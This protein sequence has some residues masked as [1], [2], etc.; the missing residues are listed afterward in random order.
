MDPI[1][2][3]QA[4]PR[5]AGLRLFAACGGRIPR[6]IPAALLGAVLLALG[7]LALAPGLSLPAQA[8][9]GPDYAPPPGLA[10]Q[11]AH[12]VTA[13]REALPA[14]QEVRDEALAGARDQA[15]E[16][17]NWPRAIAF[18]QQIVQRSLAAGAAEAASALVAL[19]GLHLEA[20]N[21]QAAAAAAFAAVE[22]AR[23][24]ADRSAGLEAL[25]NAL[26]DR[27]R[28]QE[29]AAALRAAQAA[30]PDPE[31]LQDRLSWLESMYLLQVAN[32]QVFADQSIPE[33]CIQFNRPLAQPLPLPAGDYLS[34][35]PGVRV[36]V[37][38]GADRLCIAGLEHGGSYQAVVRR[39]LP[40]AD[41]AALAADARL[42]IDI[43][44]RPA[45]LGFPTGPYVLP[46]A[47]VPAVDLQSV[48]VGLVAL[49]LV[50]ITENNLVNQLRDGLFNPLY[51]GQIDMI[52]EDI[53][54]EVWRGSMEV[55]GRLN[56]EQRTAVPLAEMLRTPEPGIYVL[57]ATNGDD[58]EQADLPWS[59]WASQWIV[60]SDIGL[61]SYQG[62]DGM[63]VVARSLQ[64]A[65]PKAG[66][67]LRLVSR[68]NQVLDRAVT[69]AQGLARFA[70][71]LLRGTGGNRPAVLYAEGARGG[72][73][74][75]LEL[76]GAALEL[77]ERGVA[78]RPAPGPVD[79]YLYADRGIF[80]PGETLDVN[81]LARDADG[82]A[83]PGMPVV[84]SLKRPD[85][86]EAARRTAVTDELGGLRTGFVI[87]D[88][89]Q[90]GQ[91]QVDA[92]ADPAAA[93][94]G[95]LQVVVE[96]FVPQRIALELHSAAAAI[97][98]GTPVTVEAR[99]EYLYGAPAADLPVKGVLTL[100]RDPEPY[101]S[102]PGYHFGL[103]EDPYSPE[104][105]PLADSRTDGEGIGRLTVL[106]DDLP[107]A[108]Q[109]LRARIAVSLFDEGGRPVNRSLTLPVHT[110]TPAIGLK[111]DFPGNQL[112]EGQAAAFDL[113]V[114]D[115]EGAPVA[116]AELDIAW[117]E[118]Q[119]DY[120]WY[121]EDG[122]LRYRQTLRDRAV[123]LSRIATDAEGRARIEQRLGWG[124]YR[125]A[126]ADRAAGAASSFRF[127][128]GW[129]VSPG[130]PDTPDALDLVLDA[131]PGGDAREV[132]A[133]VKAP[134]AGV[135]E[136]MVVNEALRYRR[137][138]PLPESGAHVSIPVQADWGVGAYV[139]A[140]AYRP[141]GGE[142]EGEVP[143][144][145]SRAMGAA[146]FPIGTAARTLS[147]ALDPPAR[148]RPGNRV[149]LPL[150]VTAT[151]PAAL[152]GGLKLAVAAVDEGV[153]QLTG[154]QSP[155]P[156]DHFFGQRR[157]AM[158]I[159]DLYGRLIAPATGQ[160]GDP[161]G[162]GDAAGN[163]GGLAVQTTRV[164]A[165]Y[166]GPVTPD[167][168]GRAVVEFDLPEGFNGRLRLMAVA[169]GRTAVGAGSAALTVRDPVV[170]SMI[171]P[172]FLAPGDEAEAMLSLDNVDGGAGSYV[173]ELAAD[174]AVD[175]IDGARLEQALDAGGRVRHRVTLSGTEVGT[176]RLALRLTGPGGLEI[177]Q[178]WEIA[179]RPA[180]P[181]QSLRS[182]DLLA[183][184]GALTSRTA[185]A[186]GMIADTATV[187]L[188]VSATPDID[189]PGLLASL[190]DY[191]YRCLEQMVSVAYPQLQ[192]R[193]MSA[194][195]QG[196]EM[197]PVA[198]EAAVQ[199]A[200]RGSI[201]RQR[202]DGSFGLW[203]MSGPADPWL[204]IYA[205][206]FLSRARG[207]G[208][209]LPEPVLVQG[210]NW[211]LSALQ[212]APDGLTA[213]GQAYAL[214]VLAR[215]AALDA[216]TLRYWADGLAE[217]VTSPLGL[218]FLGSAR[219]AAGEPL[220]QVPQLVLAAAES[221]AEPRPED[222]RDYGSSLRDAAA[223]LAV[224]AESGAP[225][226]SLLPLLTAVAD[227][228]AT[229]QRLSTQEEAW[230]L[231]A[232]QAMA[233]AG[234]PARPLLLEVAGT[235]TGPLAEPYAR[236]LP[237][238]APPLTVRNLGEEPVWAYQTVRGV[239]AASL[240]PV[241]EGLTVTRR[242]FHL[243][244]SEANPADVRQNDQMVV[245]LEGGA[246]PG[247]R[248][249]ALV[250]DLLPAGFEIE[251]A[252]AGGAVAL[253]ALPFL[254]MLSEPLFVGVRAD[255]Y[256][257]AIDLEGDTD[258]FAF[259]YL[260]RAVTPGRFVHPAPFVE[261]M[262]RPALFARGAMGEVH[263]SRP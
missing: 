59:D 200:I 86:R 92:F 243:D 61:A 101:P 244:G 134:F 168:Q 135:L 69:D 261:D 190:R 77:G 20:G 182:V 16:A 70:P 163:L 44:Q 119:A 112:A 234:G 45:S 155:D 109:P 239:P 146:W 122:R 248:H 68:N 212:N 85:G 120:F 51:G 143:R 227:S 258:R 115:A 147:V 169:W 23:E 95:S 48:N 201:A 206:D 84:L 114:V 224:L 21:A 167:A 189:V 99:G 148:A 157:L 138:V 71:G 251:S 208:Q 118:E 236:Q 228:A 136:I 52:A 177:A 213:D 15:Q 12:L 72:D 217:R 159:H 125:L 116:G 209:D 103:V 32:V 247:G 94:V 130:L 187:S 252:A 35:T 225:G 132:S 30:A 188:N 67:E 33:A 110:P 8:G 175:V 254:P 4:I 246:A 126:V 42:A 205:M 65:A 38:A 207:E 235:A 79:A 141:L 220:A 181:W 124:R 26:A 88:A 47:R 41:G 197:D 152:A 76:T 96:D 166:Q 173:A 171:L 216:S 237:G 203:S 142:A 223:T 176:G 255:R 199:E 170:S 153:L 40:Q 131:D 219:R 18:Q 106:L 83:L 7:L 25:S 75:F 179:V 29:A 193:S 198:A 113:A 250:V 196:V 253:S 195:W 238:T 164:I 137:T 17:R 62:E 260:V 2:N 259:A 241:S 27:R 156:A 263:V 64:S 226:G 178:E 204:T 191:P 202:P 233:A 56:A 192:A 91:W 58:P 50:R 242:Y 89:A 174:G 34:L 98:T 63:H 230:L 211:M 105:R 180:Q 66:V 73:F 232:A 123:E 108:G 6:R 221:G 14:P 55:D 100:E 165:L 1:R 121:W 149:S 127:Q 150:T 9:P 186:A 104:R 82:L 93:A 74:T 54:E 49:R 39:G 249:Q 5:P 145:P 183:G 154:F 36:S 172:Q 139:L 256:L 117:I 222:W 10:A 87:A 231:R 24:D 262:Y 107:D 229:R 80:R 185:A 214:Y 161:R 184:G 128:V 57:L 81:L 46:T 218:A 240:P 37:T 162:G 22:E 53:G 133:F 78:G 140:T 11:A 90:T 13:V 111:P 3:G 43:G 257:A 31:L 215:M 194:H 19:S 28:W 144:G 102:L 158:D 60:L 97:R 245:L 151:D 210:R 129:G 160:R